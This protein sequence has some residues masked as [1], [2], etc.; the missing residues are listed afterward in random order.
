MLSPVRTLLISVLAALGLALAQDAVPEH[1]LAGEPAPWVAEVKALVKDPTRIPPNQ[2]AELPE[3]GLLVYEYVNVELPGRTF[4][5]VL[6]AVKKDDPE[7]YVLELTPG[8]KGKPI[9]PEE[10]GDVLLLGQGPNF[11]VLSIREGPFKGSYLVWSTATGHRG[12]GGEAIRI[13]SQKALN[14]E[15]VLAR[16]TSKR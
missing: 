16:L 3:E 12:T 10:L 5:T 7:D 4:E 13:Y 2:T 6:L 1:R 8:N 9:A 15:P 14:R 11:W